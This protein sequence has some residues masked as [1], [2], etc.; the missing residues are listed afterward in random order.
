MESNQLEK[1]GFKKIASEL[2][3]KEDMKRKITIAYEHFRYVKQEKIDSYNEKL[4]KQTEK[5]EGKQG[6]N[7]YLVYDKLSFTPIADFRQIPPQETLDKVEKAQEIGCFD[8][9]EVCKIESTREYKDPIIFGRIK[10]CPDRF[11]VAQWDDDVKIED[12]LSET[13]G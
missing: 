4:K 6:V 2:K 9:F 1:L 11:F 12:I 10:G 3:E 7:L 8:T 5:R 13:E